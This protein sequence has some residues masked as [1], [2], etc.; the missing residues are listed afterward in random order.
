M[1]IVLAMLVSLATSGI[2]YSHA[3]PHQLQIVTP[4]DSVG[5]LGGGG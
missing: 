5:G 2:G 4:A 1:F 3:A